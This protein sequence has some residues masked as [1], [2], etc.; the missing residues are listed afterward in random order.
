MY[1]VTIETKLRTGGHKEMEPEVRVLGLR[2]ARKQAGLGLETCARKADVTVRMLLSYEFGRQQP[3]IAP[4]ARIA[5]A[6][7]VRVDRIAE[8]APAVKEVMDAGFVLSDTNGH[9][10]EQES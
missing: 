3:T 6:I 8:F 2:E 4:A 1:I 9:K 5:K 7:G 10:E